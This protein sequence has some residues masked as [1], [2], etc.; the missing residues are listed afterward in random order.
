MGEMWKG[1]GIEENSK[2][3]MIVLGVWDWTHCERAGSR[4]EKHGGVLLSAPARFGL[5]IMKAW[6]LIPAVLLLPLLTQSYASYATCRGAA[7]WN[8]LASN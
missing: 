5:Y 4:M 3:G 1:G 7:I 6:Y 2:C 8:C